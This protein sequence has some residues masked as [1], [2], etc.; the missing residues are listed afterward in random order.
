MSLRGVGAS[1]KHEVIRR[2]VKFSG[3]VVTV[4]VEHLRLP[5][6]V[7]VHHEILDMP[8]SVAVVP[9]LEGAGGIDV[10]LVEQFRSALRGYIHEIPAGIVDPG[11]DPAVCAV[12]EL[13]EET[14]FVARSLTHLAHLLPIPGTS[15]HC[16]DFYLAEDLEVG[17]QE[18]ED[19]ECLSVR[20]VPFA[21]L[22]ATVLTGSEARNDAGE[23][24]WVVDSKTHLGLLH[25]AMLRGELLR[26][27]LPSGGVRRDASRASGGPS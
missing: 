25:V 7:E 20:R 22:V 4:S 11:E 15:A 14:G 16:M 2:E 24:A 12:R 27:G 13:K 9:L 3:T 18:L 26:G 17:T 21:D 8:R 6:G 1:E 19:A 5:N 10:I 23:P